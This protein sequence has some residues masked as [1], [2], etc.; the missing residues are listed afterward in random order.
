[1]FN[2]TLVLL[3]IILVVSLFQNGTGSVY[4]VIPDDHNST[5]V[6][7]Y[8]LRH[9]LNDTNKYF[10]SNVQV[11]F[12]PGQYYLNQEL[13]V[14]NVSNF[15][16]TGNRTKEMINT[17]INCSPSPA[18][19]VVVNSSSIVIANIALNGCSGNYRYS[20]IANNITTSL[21]VFNCQLFTCAYFSSSC[22]HNACGISL[23]DSYQNTTLLHMTSHY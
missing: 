1:M 14:H 2:Y 5:N 13:I 22:D 10:T 7:T 16:L 3:P 18:G 8:V 4:F 17:V 11:Q 23:V 19:I 6:N 15:S 9:Y 21:F 20:V 12:Y